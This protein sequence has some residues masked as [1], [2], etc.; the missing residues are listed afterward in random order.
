MK[1]EN[2]NKMYYDYTSDSHKIMVEKLYLINSAVTAQE[3][4][5]NIHSIFDSISKKLTVPF[6]HIYTVGSAHM[7]FSIKDNHPF[8]K[9]VSDLDVAIVDQHLFNKYMIAIL[10]ETNYYKKQQGFKIRH[11][12]I[13]GEKKEYS[14][15]KSYKENLAKGII[16]PRYFPIGETKESWDKFFYEITFK[17]TDIFQKITACIFLSEECF[18]LKQESNIKYFKSQ[19]PRGN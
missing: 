14:D 2:K 10:E 16:H 4:I 6:R 9:G 15:F 17:H 12:I 18:R 5:N 1:N 7:G 11:E 19:Q 3:Y 13:D 8:N